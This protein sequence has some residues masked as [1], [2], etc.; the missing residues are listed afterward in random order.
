[1]PITHRLTTDTLQQFIY[2]D[3]HGWVYAKLDGFHF[4]TVFQPIY[5]RSLQVMAYEGLS[6]ITDTDNQPVDPQ[7]FFTSLNADAAREDLVAAVCNIVHLYNFTR[8]GEHAADKQIFINTPP[9]VFERRA[10]D[11]LKLARGLT[12]MAGLGLNP[13]NLV[14]EIQEFPVNCF[15]KAVSGIH[16]LRHAGINIALDD[17]G[18]G[19]CDL[20]R[21]QIVAPD[22]VKLDKTLIQNYREHTQE[23][24][25]II[26]YCKSRQIKVF[27]EG[28]ETEEQ[29]NH[30]R[31]LPIEGFQ[32]YYLCKPKAPAE[33][34]N[35]QPYITSRDQESLQS[36]LS[37]NQ[38]SV[39]SST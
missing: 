32:G 12:D 24:K 18:T 8:L 28:I 21:V 27:A 9:Q 38:T 35:A 6:R 5:D 3:H 19:S 17:Y 29:L 13:H 23:L 39:A 2:T 36:A 31:S 11:E 37:I 26:E 10:S 7:T 14:C 25:E 30:F 15:K 33:L 16:M 22:I 4:R 34:T 20:N 1:M